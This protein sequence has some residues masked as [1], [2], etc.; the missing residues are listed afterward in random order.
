MNLINNNLID[1][2]ISAAETLKSD[3]VRILTEYK[4]ESS[5]VKKFSQRLKDEDGYYQEEQGK[6]AATARKSIEAAEKAFCSR[7]EDLSGRMETELKKHLSEP[8]NPQFRERLSMLAEFGL[9]PEKIEI[10]NLIAL[11][12]G[13]QMGLAAL[14]KTLEKVES[15]FVLK[16]HTTADYQS[17]IAEIRDICRNLKYIPVDFLHE[18]TEIYKGVSADYIFPDGHVSGNGISYDS[19]T[20]SKHAWFFENE[21]EKI[22]CLKNVWAAD[23]SYGEADQI[24]TEE[25]EVRKEI[26]EQLVQQGY[27]AEELPNPQTATSIEDNP[28][29]SEAMQF[30]LKDGRE[31]ALENNVLNRLAGYEKR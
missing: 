25:I 12:G 7:V 14:A 1:L 16:Y 21:L 22:T 13:N 9:Q 29:S 24:S 19:M 2:L 8:V 18:G 28:E 20:L 23:C 4:K 26:N 31:R 30:A 15:P 10:E 11:N 17:D 3:V 6:L 27:Q 5:T